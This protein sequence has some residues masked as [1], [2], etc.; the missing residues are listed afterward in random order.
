MPNFTG[1]IE[2]G[3]GARFLE[4]SSI[5]HYRNGSRHNENGPAIEYPN[6]NKIWY[7]NGERLTKKQWKTLK[8]QFLNENKIKK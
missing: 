6:G 1:I 8:G 7:L 4:L 3:D 5:E 2:Y